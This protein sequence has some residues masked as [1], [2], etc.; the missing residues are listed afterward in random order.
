VTL[1]LQEIS[2]RIQNLI[3]NLFSLHLLVKDDSQK[4]FNSFLSNETKS[5]NDSN[6]NSPYKIN[7]Q[8]DLSDY[9]REELSLDQKS[10]DLKKLQ[11]IENKY[12]KVN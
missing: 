10:A 2:L 7:N 9:I 8:M 3:N 11:N 4:N 12:S 6:P 5:S 1:S